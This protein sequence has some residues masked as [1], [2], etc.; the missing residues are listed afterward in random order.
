MPTCSVFAQ[1][2]RGAIAGKI[3]DQ[4]GVAVLGALIE[5]KN[6]SSG[7]IYKATSSSSGNY[8]FEGLVPGAYEISIPYFGYL[9]ARQNITVQAGQDLP[10]DIRVTDNS[11]NTVGEDRSFFAAHNG[12]H[13]TPKGPAPHT[14]EG[15]QRFWRIVT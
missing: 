7:A 2:D 3:T 10:L 13:P 11:L 6:S 5:A 15:P 1:N 14:R 4:D 8:K 9:A 12:S